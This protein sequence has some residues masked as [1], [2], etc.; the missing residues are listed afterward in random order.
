MS[1]TRHHSIT[2]ALSR[3]LCRLVPA[4][5]VSGSGTSL[6][7]SFEPKGVF[8]AETAKPHSGGNL[9]YIAGGVVLLLL[10]MGVFFFILQKPVQ[11]PA[12]EPAPPVVANAERVNPMAQP[13][14]I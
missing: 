3:W 6:T 10:A 11:A 7:T 8:V 5:S 12:P 14:L 13:S 1:P 4:G 2:V 9:K